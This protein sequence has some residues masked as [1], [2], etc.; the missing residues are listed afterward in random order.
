MKHLFINNN[1]LFP[2]LNVLV[3]VGGT[4]ND[5]RQKFRDEDDSFCGAAITGEIR[6][7]K[8]DD[9][10]G[11]CKFTQLYKE[12]WQGDVPCILIHFPYVTFDHVYA[13]DVFASAIIAHECLHAA[14]Y[15]ME[16]YEIPYQEKEFFARIQQWLFTAISEWVYE[17]FLQDDERMKGGGDE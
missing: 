1:S 3:M 16:H 2:D 10:S 9:H 5:W 14:Q 7:F 12:G 6:M 11:Y 13:P 15:I 17:N 4:E 8:A